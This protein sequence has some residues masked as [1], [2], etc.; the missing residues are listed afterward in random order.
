M[1]VNLTLL[2]LSLEFWGGFLAC[3]LFVVSDY[4]A[5]VVSCVSSLLTMLVLYD[6]GYVLLYLFLDFLFLLRKKECFPL[7]L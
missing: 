2:C 5:M 4:S 3:Y 7:M 6:S 1:C